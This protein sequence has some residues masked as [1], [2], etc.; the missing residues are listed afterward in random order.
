M[1]LQKESIKSG[2]HEFL[3]FGLKQAQ[4]AIFAGSFFVNII[5][6]NATKPGN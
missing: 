1:R 2:M 3:I 5:S 6:G 4:A